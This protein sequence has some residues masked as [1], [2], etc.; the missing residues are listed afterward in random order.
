MNRVVVA[1][2]AVGVRGGLA[3][4]VPQPMR[5]PRPA[6]RSPTAATTTR[7]TVV[8][9]PQGVPGLAAVEYVR[10]SDTVPVCSGGHGILAACPRGKGAIAGGFIV[11]SSSLLRVVLSEPLGSR[12]GRAS[13]SGWFVQIANLDMRAH[14]ASAAARKGSDDR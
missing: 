6:R 5:T 8:R 2:V 9:G 13:A 10:K 4:A 7:V 3:A 14:V 1:A 11:T 12:S